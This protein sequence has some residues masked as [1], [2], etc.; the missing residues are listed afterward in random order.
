[1]D[2]RTS[3]VNTYKTYLGREPEAGII[4]WRL[5]QLKITPLDKQIQQIIASPEA[6]TYKNN[7]AFAPL[8]SFV[9]NYKNDMSSLLSGQKA[10]QEGLFGQYQSA[11]EGQEKLP[12]LYSRLQNEAGIPGLNTALQGYKD[13]IYRVKDL[14][15]HLDEDVTS[16]NLGTY[17]TEAMRRRI[18]AS[19]G[20]DL[21]TQLGRIGT[22]MEPV[23]DLLTG[24]N[25]QVATMLGLTTQQMDKDLQPL[26][27][28]INSI[29]DRFAREI[30]G[31]TQSR[32]ME[33]TG[34]LQKLERDNYL[35][36]REWELAQ[37]LAK[38]ERDFSRQKTLAAQ[39]LAKYTYQP[40]SAPAYKASTPVR[41]L[42]SLSVSN[43]LQPA[44]ISIQPAASTN[45]LQ[46]GGGINLQGG[47]GFSLQGGGGIRLQ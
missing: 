25:N 8:N 19:E 40:T 6:Q 12:A 28:R 18:L 26:M 13:Q 46:G 43:V 33:L 9:T 30:T 32:E 22:G 44:N 15:D 37:Q 7:Q 31:F 16:R 20:E 36:D 35:A 2:P 4:D 34:I 42:P 10:E 17:T 45:Y 14:L 27:L 39:S 21:R 29:S 47:G 23:V 38:E 5:G 1:M 41:A 11:I 24:A 3:L